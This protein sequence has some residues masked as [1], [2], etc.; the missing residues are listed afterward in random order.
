MMSDT[1]AGQTNYITPYSTLA[2]AFVENGSCITKQEAMRF[3]ASALM[4]PVQELY[5]DYNKV[6][7]I[8]LI[9]A[10]LLVKTGKIPSNFESIQDTTYNLKD[11]LKTLELI[12][13]HGQRYLDEGYTV[14]E[15]IDELYFHHFYKKTKLNHK[16]V[17]NFKTEINFLN[18]KLINESSD[19][20]DDP[21]IYK[22]ELSDGRVFFDRDLDVSFAK[23]GNYTVSLTVS[24][25]QYDVTTIKEIKVSNRKSCIKQPLRA[26]CKKMSNQITCSVNDVV[27]NNCSIFKN[28]KPEH[29]RYLWTVEDNVVYHG[30]E[31][32]HNIVDPNKNIIKLLVTDGIETDSKTIE[33]YSTIIENVENKKEK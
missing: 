11:I 22:W 7:G 18:V 21:L 15:I 29:I 30:Q 20:D 31:F 32:V 14:S 5:K 24:D 17:A 12:R 26:I 23:P 6:Q 19:V 9:A 8:P 1:V 27:I 4:V 33:L 2:Q 10:E 25:H 28:A 3:F 16:P 13:V